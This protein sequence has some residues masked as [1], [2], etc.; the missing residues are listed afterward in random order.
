MGF[1]N[2]DALELALSAR[3][4]IIR[5]GSIVT[6]LGMAVGGGIGLRGTISEML[7]KEGE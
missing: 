3:S 6:G 7:D 5:I 1:F 4:A 2:K